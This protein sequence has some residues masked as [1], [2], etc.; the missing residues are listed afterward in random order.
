ML[1]QSLRRG[2]NIKTTSVQRLAFAVRL[3]EHWYDTGARHVYAFPDWYVLVVPL[4]TT[5]RPAKN[6]NVVVNGLTMSADVDATRA[7]TTRHHQVPRISP[8]VSLVYLVPRTQRR[9]GGAELDLLELA[10][11]TSSKVDFLDDA[12]G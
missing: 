6:C 7:V 2:P 12:L 3:D 5:S 1:G 4:V 8:Q 10:R 9:G 11:C